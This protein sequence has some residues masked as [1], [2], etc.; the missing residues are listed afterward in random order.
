MQI[1]N[2]IAPIVLAFAGLAIL[3]F[4]LTN[5]QTGWFNF[6]GSAILLVGIIATL[7]TLDL[8]SKSTRLIVFALLV[9]V[10]IGLMFVNYK[11]IK[12]PLDFQ[13][14]KNKRYSYVIQNLKDIREVQMKYKE[15]Y[16]KFTS[17]LD[18]MMTFL[19]NDSILVIKSVG[20]APDTLTEAQAIELGI[21]KRDTT[22]IPAGISIFNT[23]YL[24]DRKGTFHIDS[25][26]FVPFS[27]MAFKMNAGH[28]ERGR[29]KVPV[30]KVTDAAPFDIYD[31]LQVGSMVDPST[32]GNWGE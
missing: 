9:V 23:E 15:K 6:G 17:E 27:R 19:K 12:D 14:E 18:T 21:I 31:V 20:T 29:V 1:K 16:G 11:S 5:T 13:A 10:S 4:G 2:A 3:L 8:F 22:A 25:L 30:F 7:S 28:V 24:G 32:A 26:P